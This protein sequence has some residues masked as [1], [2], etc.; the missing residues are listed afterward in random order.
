M[1]LCGVAQKALMPGWFAKTS[2]K[3]LDAGLHAAD[4]R[5]LVAIGLHANAEGWAYPSLSTLADIAHV[6]RTD[7]PRHTRRLEAAGLIEIRRRP[8][9]GN[10]Y[11]QLFTVS[12]GA[13]Q[14]ESEQNKEQK[15]S[16]CSPPQLD[17]LGVE[18]VEPTGPD[19]TEAQPSHLDGE[20]IPPNPGGKNG[21]SRRAGIPPDWQPDAAN[22]Q[23]ALANGLNPDDER[24]EFVSFW[25]GDGGVKADW[26]ATFRNSL[27]KR[28]GGAGGAHRWGQ[29]RGN[30]PGHTSWA[31][32]IARAVPV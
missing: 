2:A 6:L 28:I 24:E 15:D 10:C 1:F 31:A 13:D 7:I 4:W 16:P 19:L 9:F 20:V 11:R 5:V 14:T 27:L 18:M 8:G 30:R 23:F 22:C 26:Q 3:A 25:R 21:R 12:T 29:P 17:L 32:A